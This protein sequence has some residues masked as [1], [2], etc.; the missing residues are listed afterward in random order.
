MTILGLTETFNTMNRPE[1][2]RPERTNTTNICG[3]MINYI[4]DRSFDS[5]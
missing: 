5:S 3:A 1:P 4:I 2:T